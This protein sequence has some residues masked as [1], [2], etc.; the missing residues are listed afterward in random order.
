LNNSV[1]TQKELNLIIK[2]DV[3]GSIEAIVGSLEKVSVEGVQDQCGPFSCRRRCHGKLTSILAV[4]SDSVII[5]FNVRPTHGSPFR[6]MQNSGRSKSALY[7]IIY[8]VLED[9]EAAMKGMLDPVFTKKKS[10]GQ[11]EVRQT[12]KASKIG[13][14]AGCYVTTGIILRNAE[15]RLLRDSI[16]IYEGKLCFLEEI[17]RRCARSQS[18][19][20]MRHND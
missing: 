2:G 10:L 7:N 19:L 5:A 11:A 15:V 6:I 9:I 16:V 4:A 3:H 12:F 1:P 18:W 8:K 14:I 17:Q 20:G 13:T